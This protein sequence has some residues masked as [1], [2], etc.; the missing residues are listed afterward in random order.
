MRIAS[1][2]TLTLMLL[3]IAPVAY[4]AGPTATTASP[5]A[6]AATPAP[7]P[8]PGSPVA[9]PTPDLVGQPTQTTDTNAINSTRAGS[10]SDGHTTLLFLSLLALAM[11]AA[12]GVFIWYEGRKRGASDRRR[13]RM[14]SGRTPQTAGL[15]A[16][17]GNAPPPPPRKRRSQAKRKKR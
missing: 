8:A 15:T 3:A 5:T 12:V 13:K 1:R 11:I 17:T 14:R 2:I 16:A 4:A 10:S 9:N 6:T 7:T